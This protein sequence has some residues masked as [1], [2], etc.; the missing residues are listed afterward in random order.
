[1]QNCNQYSYFNYI[2]IRNSISIEHLQSEIKYEMFDLYKTFKLID[3]KYI[4]NY[5]NQVSTVD[6]ALVKYQVTNY[7]IWLVS[8]ILF[9]NVQFVHNDYIHFNCIFHQQNENESGSYRKISQKLRSTKPVLLI[10]C[11]YSHA[12]LKQS[13][14][15]SDSTRAFSGT[16]KAS[17]VM[18]LHS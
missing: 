8:T 17:G 13:Q 18:D 3:H 11:R 5:Y 15:T 12:P 2:G 16:P 6:I 10:P 1:V 14:V 7:Y 9:H 4:H